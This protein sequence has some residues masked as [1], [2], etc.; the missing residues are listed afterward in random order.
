MLVSSSLA[1]VF[2]KP[3]TTISSAGV[4]PEPGSSAT[5]GLKTGRLTNAAADHISTLL[6]L[7]SR[8]SNYRN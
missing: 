8:I 4:T 2:L 6:K 5:D 7:M 1:V 3:E